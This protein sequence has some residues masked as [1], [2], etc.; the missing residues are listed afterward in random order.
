VVYTLR[1]KFYYLSLFYR[2]RQQPEKFSLRLL[3]FRPDRV[4]ETST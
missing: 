2:G 3:L 4:Y 1:L